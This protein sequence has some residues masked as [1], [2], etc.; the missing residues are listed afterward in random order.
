MKW[1]LLILLLLVA[2]GCAS[3]KEKCFELDVG[4]EGKIEAPST[5]WFAI[6]LGDVKGP[7]K[8][9]SC[10]VVPLAPIVPPE[11]PDPSVLP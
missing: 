3:L 11:M 1:L 5:A 7:V 8:L 2:V 9:R 6:T 4:P 10:P